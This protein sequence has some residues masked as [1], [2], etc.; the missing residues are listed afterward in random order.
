MAHVGPSPTA[1]PRRA[2]SARPPGP[3]SNLTRVLTHPR[4][5]FGTVFRVLTSDLTGSQHVVILRRFSVSACSGAWVRPVPF[6]PA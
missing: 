6:P 1:E 4:R 2:R 5:V 3:S